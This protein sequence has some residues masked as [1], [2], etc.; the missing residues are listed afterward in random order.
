MN[1]DSED[2]LVMEPEFLMGWFA[3]YWAAVHDPLA[4]TIEQ[5]QAQAEID[6]SFITQYKLNEDRLKADKA[7]LVES[8]REAIKDEN[9]P[10][11]ACMYHSLDE[12]FGPL[13]TKFR[14]GK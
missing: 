12:R 8:M 14:E 1:I 6:K 11:Y 9:A 5:L 2:N 7:E 10:A 13:I 4:T 3:S